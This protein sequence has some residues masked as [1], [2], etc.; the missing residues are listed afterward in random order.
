MQKTGRAT[1]Q[2]R[3]H[4]AAKQSTGCLCVTEATLVNHTRLQQPT[5]VTSS[6]FVK[7]AERVRPRFHE[8]SRSFL[9]PVAEH[10][11]NGEVQAL[12]RIFPLP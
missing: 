12:A 11:L 5:V 4:R 3:C 10:K 2:R 8:T 7:L 1:C 9:F 6:I